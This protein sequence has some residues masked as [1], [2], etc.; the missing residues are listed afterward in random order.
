M[1]KIVSFVNFII[2]LLV[3]LAGL[4][5]LYLASQGYPEK[6][7]QI[8]NT[9]IY[10]YKLAIPLSVLLIIL[11]VIYV[12]GKLMTIGTKPQSIYFENTEGKVSISNT[13]ITDFVN[14]ICGNYEEVT[15]AESKVHASKSKKGDMVIS[16]SMD[17]LGGTNIPESIEKLQQNIRRQLNELLGL[18][19]IESVEINIAKIISQEKESSEE[20]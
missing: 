16:I 20:F 9:F 3:F 14:R 19:N 12:L 8:V 10:D 11:P 7:R 5:L 2:Q 18:E 4:G 15:H 17:I 1:K 6:I 13:A